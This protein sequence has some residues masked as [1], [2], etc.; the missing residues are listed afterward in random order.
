MATEISK[1]N[2]Q[3]YC[4]SICHFNTCKLTDYNRHLLTQK[5]IRN[6]TATDG[7]INLEKTSYICENCGK[8]YNDRTGLWRHNKKCLSN[9]QDK[10]IYTQNTST[11]GDKEI[12]YM[13]SSIYGECTYT[14]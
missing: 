10:E 13:F 9:K 14:V 2:E 12:E 3:N 8:E 4:C 6:K 5:H 7:N 1:K 11:I